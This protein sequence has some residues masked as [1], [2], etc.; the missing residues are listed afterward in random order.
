MFVPHGVG[1]IHDQAEGLVCIEYF[2]EYS[3]DDVNLVLLFQWHNSKLKLARK[4]DTEGE[5]NRFY[6]DEVIHG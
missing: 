4:F 5:L 1:H 3:L 6:S 2:F